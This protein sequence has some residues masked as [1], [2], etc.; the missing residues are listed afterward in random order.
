MGWKEENKACKYEKRGWKS[1]RNNF[2]CVENIEM[3]LSL[4]IA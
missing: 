3:M 4:I 1:E 2:K